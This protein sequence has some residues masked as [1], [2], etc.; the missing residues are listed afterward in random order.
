MVA[1]Y[2]T[3][4]KILEL[5]NIKNKS[6]LGNNIRVD[7]NWI[8]QHGVPGTNYGQSDTVVGVSDNNCYLAQYAAIK[9]YMEPL[10]VTNITE[11]L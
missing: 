8:T 11:L 9:A 2:A 5:L 6:V 1:N 10:E 4:L 3:V 7:K